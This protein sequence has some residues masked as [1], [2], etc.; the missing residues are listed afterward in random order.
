[1]TRSGA[2]DT[3]IT[4]LGRLRDNPDNPQAWGEVVEQYGR[5][6]FRWCRR[7]N[8]QEADAEDVT[9]TVLLQL[10]AKLRHFDYDPARSFRAW[11]KTLAQH[12]LSDV[13][14]KHQRPGAGSGDSQVAQ[15]MATV[16]ARDDLAQRLEEDYDRELLQQAMRR[17]QERVQPRTWEAF[18]LLTLEGA[19]GAEAAA[20][21]Q[22]KVAT[23]FVHKS[24]VQKLLQEEVRQLEGSF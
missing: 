18:R 14:A 17:V 4:L 1:M 6:I 24:N 13:M 16:A 23:V 8:L 11:L 7:W 3:R 12:A 21:L 5:T 9:Q 22:M 19:S 10:A 2:D 15:L 20:R